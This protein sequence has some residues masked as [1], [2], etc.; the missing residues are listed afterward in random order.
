MTRCPVP[1][2]LVALFGWGLF[3]ALV[4]FAHARWRSLRFRLSPERV[5]SE[6]GA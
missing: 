4:A 6:P 3:D 5:G 1:Y 2:A